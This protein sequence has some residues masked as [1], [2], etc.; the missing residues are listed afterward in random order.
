MKMDARWEKSAAWGQYV[1]IIVVVRRGRLLGSPSSRKIF[2]VT[3]GS[4]A[5]RKGKRRLYKVD[6]RIQVVKEKK[7]TPNMNEED[8]EEGW[9][10]GGK[11][12]EGFPRNRESRESELLTR[13]PEAKR[14]ADHS[15]H[16]VREKP[17]LFWGVP[18]ILSLISF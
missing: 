5:Q 7:K 3:V 1:S 16:Q 8:G 12:K 17:R 15:D 13:K 10:E 2:I 18:L 4:V 6:I 14:A 11:R 9:W